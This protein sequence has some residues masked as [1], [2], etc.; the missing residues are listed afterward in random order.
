LACIV[1]CRCP[2]AVPEASKR[3]LCLWS[4]TGKRARLGAYHGEELAF[5]DDSFPSGWGSSTGD[6]TFGEVM[7]HTGAS[8]R[9]LAIQ[10]HWGSLSGPHTTRT[11]IRFSNWDTISGSA[12]L[13]ASTIIFAS[14]TAS[15]MADRTLGLLLCNSLDSTFANFIAAMQTAKFRGRDSNSLLGERAF[16]LSVQFPKKTG[17]PRV[18]P[19]KFLYAGGW[20]SAFGIL[21]RSKRRQ[22]AAKCGDFISTGRETAEIRTVWRRERDSL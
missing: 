20:F 4:E 18:R 2:D 10:I 16:E 13:A 19:E 1:G 12:R 7:R 11:Q 17:L 3:E 9:R 8:L 5:L 6:E 15:A 21:R 22:F 14:V